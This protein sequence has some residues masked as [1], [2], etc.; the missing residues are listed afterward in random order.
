MRIPIFGSC[1]TLINSRQFEAK[2]MIFR[3]LD[4]LE[5]EWRSLG[6]TDY[7]TKC[8]LHEVHVLAKH[9]SGGLILGFS[10]FETKTGTWKKGTRSQSKQNKLIAFPTPWNQIEAGILFALR[11]PLLVFCEDNVSGGIFEKGITDLFIHRMPLGK[12]SRQN[13]KALNEVIVKW[14]HEVREHYDNPK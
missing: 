13:K 8:P 5:L 14:A 12:L 3:Q 6:Q 9:C 2:K 10:Q 4:R 11:L 7:P 1:P